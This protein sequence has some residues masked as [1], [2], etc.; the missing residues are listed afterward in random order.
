[1][2]KNKLFIAITLAIL[3]ISLASAG[4]QYYYPSYDSSYSGQGDGDYYKKS[5]LFKDDEITTNYYPWGSEKVVLSTTQ[6]TLIEKKYYPDYYPQRNYHGPYYPSYSNWRYKM[7]Y[8]HYN[9]G[10]NSYTKPYYYQSI[11]D[12]NLG[13]YNWRY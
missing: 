5:T 1:M 13:Y 4:Y 6:K 11:Y 8:S 2:I 7:P 10:S 12:Y 9:Y 3:S